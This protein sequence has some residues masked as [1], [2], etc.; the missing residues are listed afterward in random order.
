MKETLN[1]AL[2]IS[3]VATI[4]VPLTGVHIHKLASVIFLLLS[5]VHTVVY[6]KQLNARHWLLLAMIVLSFVTGLLGM[7][8]DQV[9]LDLAFHIGV[10]FAVLILAVLRAQNSS[11]A[12]HGTVRENA[13]AEGVR[14]AYRK[15]TFQYCL[16]GSS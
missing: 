12:E 3:F 14:A 16:Q 9:S 7:I 10:L 2:L 8:L 1:Y 4:M 5:M 13:E 15:S 6:R 11:R